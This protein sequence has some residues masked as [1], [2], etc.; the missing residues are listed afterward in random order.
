MSYLELLDRF[1][2][3][4]AKP[5]AKADT[6][7]EYAARSYWRL[8][9][10]VLILFLLAGG[11]IGGLMSP[12]PDRYL[13][14]L[15]PLFDLFK[16]ANILR[17]LPWSLGLVVLYLLIGLIPQFRAIRDYLGGILADAFYFTTNT[18]INSGEWCIRNRGVSMLIIGFLAFAIGW[19]ATG[20]FT[21]KSKNALLEQGLN[22]W[23]TEAERFVLEEPLFSQ[24]P[25]RLKDLEE[26]WQN[27][28]G[29]IMQQRGGYMHTA[30]H[31]H[32]AIQL[33]NRPEGGR[34]YIVYLYKKIDKFNDASGNAVEG[35][36][37][38]AAKCKNLPPRHPD[39][40]E[41]EVRAC[42]V[43]N[44]LLAKLYSR[45]ADGDEVLRY[46]A[47][48]DSR[49]AD[50]NT[51]DEQRFLFWK[52]TESYYRKARPTDYENLPWGKRHL[53]SVSNGMGN[54][55][56]GMIDYLK[57][58][59]W[60]VADAPCNKINDCVREALDSYD[61]AEKNLA[62][63]QNEVQAAERVSR[64]GGKLANNRIDLLARLAMNFDLISGKL[65]RE[66]REKSHMENKVALEK[67][68]EENIV[69][70]TSHDATEADTLKDSAVTIAQAYG[71]CVKLN[72]SD[73]QGGGPLTK[74]QLARAAGLYLRIVNSFEPKNYDDWGPTYFCSIAR[75]DSLLTTF[76]CAVT[77]DALS[78]MPEL[79]LGELI[80]KIGQEC[81]VPVKPEELRKKCGQQT[82]TKP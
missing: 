10:A 66:T 50:E 78:G 48:R 30:N 47:Q 4:L 73:G 81:S 15:G 13:T 31:L 45:F 41:S 51:Q 61:A 52:Q 1:V 33:L 74:Q 71:A 21:T 64:L 79:P 16:P 2:T 39:T 25:G 14:Y 32:D 9:A 54:V 49:L 37:G 18:L 60:E 38:I 80:A 59:N 17:T 7:S 26:L 63:G 22:R 3:R 56:A 70:I 5:F 34:D 53:F 27:E 11:Y 24:K 28:Y 62:L 72:E 82:S 68:I 12:T 6:W 69:Q 46:M 76:G 23:L 44:I 75:D 29:D 40:R 19:A 36:D 57:K 42:G 43:L 58:H 35:F 65:E 67:Y 20:F 8:G 77:D 55:Y